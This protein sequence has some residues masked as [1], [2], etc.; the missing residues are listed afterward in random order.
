MAT[1]VRARATGRR[2]RA[3][4][5]PGRLRRDI[6][7]A[8]FE[9]VPTGNPGTDPSD[10]GLFAAASVG[11]FRDATAL[12][13]TALGVSA[14]VDAQREKKI[15]EDEDVRREYG[16]DLPSASGDGG[17]SIG[18]G[19]G[20]GWGGDDG[21]WGSDDRRSRLRRFVW[22]RGG[23]NGFKWLAMFLL[24]AWWCYFITDDPYMGTLWLAC[25]IACGWGVFVIAGA[26]FV[27]AFLANFVLQQYLVDKLDDVHGE[28]KLGF[29]DSLFNNKRAVD[30]IKS[31]RYSK[32]IPEYIME[33]ENR[34]KHLN[35][36][37][38]Q[39]VNIVGTDTQIAQIKLSP[40]EEV[41]ASPGA[42]CYMSSNVMSVTSLGPG[43]LPRAIM[44][45]LAGE[46]FFL[47]TF[48]NLGVT[49][50]YIAV[51]GLE[52]SDKIAVI[53]LKDEIKHDIL[54][55][56]DSYMCSKGNVRIT[57]AAALR[58]G[59]DDFDSFSDMLK[60]RIGLAARL[61]LS[62][63]NSIFNGEWLT[64]SGTVCITGKGTVVRRTLKKDEE[65]VVDAR[66]VMALE[67]S[68]GYEL[69][70]QNS[71]LAAVFGGAG[72]FFVRLQGPGTFYLQ[73]LPVQKQLDSGFRLGG[74]KL[75]VK[76]Q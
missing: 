61:V 76:T 31:G 10:W 33:S 56:R 44:R 67:R 8:L 57:A 13:A 5:T 69:E 36:I 53:E 50:G 39:D 64:G 48:K 11:T 70:V 2:R 47:N 12:V 60:Y 4:A 65:L 29:F 35:P 66:S 7:R 14:S 37:L 62:K 34:N 15:R 55:A 26:V 20:R 17:G 21:D 25:A 40:G 74:R 49:E 51:G 24:C 46:P 16:F 41:A 73:S 28:E 30:N 75:K 68:V 3:A 6:A 58:S 9:S 71:P 38:P 45:A 22:V 63:G 54:C 27:A 18:S 52:P 59:V 1:S 19:D 32:T 23:R 72:L 43:G 42:M